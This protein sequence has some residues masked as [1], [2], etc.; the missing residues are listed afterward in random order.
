MKTLSALLIALACQIGMGSEYIYD[1]RGNL[2]EVRVN[3]EQPYYNP[4]NN[5]SIRGYG[6][7]G[8]V[9]PRKKFK[10]TS[11]ITIRTNTV[12]VNKAVRYVETINGV[13]KTNMIFK[14]VPKQV[15]VTNA[16]ISV[17]NSL[18]KKNRMQRPGLR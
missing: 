10:K 6:N 18:I 13:T 14:K 15:V 8:Y 12:W 2:K 5:R 3:T 16:C 17:V 7:G 1:S 4:N 9:H 11:N